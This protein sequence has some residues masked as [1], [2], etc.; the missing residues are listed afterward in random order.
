MWLEHR[1]WGEGEGGWDPPGGTPPMGP[2]NVGV[3]ASSEGQ[4]PSTLLLLAAGDTTG[5][6]VWW[7]MMTMCVWVCKELKGLPEIWSLRQIRDGMKRWPS[8]LPLESRGGLAILVQVQGQ[9]R[10]LPA[11]HRWEC[12]RRAW[13]A[14]PL[15]WTKRTATIVAHCKRHWTLCL[16]QFCHTKACVIVFVIFLNSIE[17]ASL[18]F[19]FPWSSYS[20]ITFI[21]YLNHWRQGGPKDSDWGSNT[22]RQRNAFS[23]LCPWVMM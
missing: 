12:N 14:L 8:G 11:C 3:R 9:Y 5:V 18:K 2:P 16:F 20:L 7:A 19:L 6:R 4:W 23:A 10:S 17:F 22:H 1:G 21:L 15:H 13:K